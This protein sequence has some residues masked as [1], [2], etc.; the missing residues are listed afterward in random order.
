MA[1]RRPRTPPTRP[2]T[3]ATTPRSRGT[4]APTSSRSRCPGPTRTSGRSSPWRT[5][6]PSGPH[7]T[8]PRLPGPD[9]HA[10]PI[11]PLGILCPGGRQ[12]LDFT[13]AAP[14]PVSGCPAYVY[15]GDSKGAGSAAAAFFVRQTGGPCLNAD[16]PDT[17]IAGAPPGTTAL[18]QSPVTPPSL[19]LSGLGSGR[20]LSRR[21]FRIH[22]RAPKGQRLRR[23]TV[24][25]AG[26]RARVTRRG[27]RLTAIIDLRHAPRG[28]FAVRVSAVTVSGRRVSEQR[29]YRTCTPRRTRHPARS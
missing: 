2:T 16:T 11:C 24:V 12:L 6:A 7:C 14:E 28:R 19:G 8:Q 4:S 27:T 20:C 26:R 9:G 1:R 29:R 13:T 25:V 17:T 15:G 5:P 22:L 10:G 21:V 23:A 3:G 18:P